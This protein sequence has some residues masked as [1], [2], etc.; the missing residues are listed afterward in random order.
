MTFYGKTVFLVIPQGFASRYL[1]RTDIFRVL[2]ASGVC[3]V[4]VTPNPDELYF[5]QEFEDDN[6]FIEKFEHTEYDTFYSPSR[7]QQFLQFVSLL[8]LNSAGDLAAIRRREARERAKLTGWKGQVWWWGARPIIWLLRN[9][10]VLRRLLIRSESRFFVP[11]SHRKLFLQYQPD[12]VVVTSLGFWRHD[13]YMMRE[14]QRHSVE[15]MSVILSWDN[16][17]TKGMASATADHVIAWTENMKQELVEYHDVEPDTIFVGGVAHFDTHFSKRSPIA[18]PELF[19]QTRLDPHRK[20]ILF[21]T[22]SPTVY[23][24]LNLSVI[25]AI[26]QAIQE[27]RL[28]H[29][30][31]LLVRLHPI[32]LG[33]GITRADESRVEQLRNLASKFPYVFLDIPE[34]RSQ[35]LGFDMPSSDMHRL[36]AMLE[37][38][39]VMVNVYST[40]MLE[41][42]IFDLPIVNAGFDTFNEKLQGKNSCVE[43]YPHLRRVLSTGCARTAHNEEELIELINTYLNCPTLDSEGRALVV[44]NEC[45]SNQGTAGSAIARYILSLFAP[46]HLAGAEGMV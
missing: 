38:A 41:A 10:R 27:N 19:E 12:L 30:C 40:L 43:R 4:I 5:R 8:T 15:V 29:P 46:E 23:S 18:R 26:G 39:D 9:N 20:L 13:A 42:C 33:R 25:E 21:G 7:P 6:V 16:P 22:A 24:D 2:K 14:A 11:D 45:G 35:Q 17:S 3:I 28:A 44:T 31:Q 1:L 34:A 32:Y 37:N 36:R